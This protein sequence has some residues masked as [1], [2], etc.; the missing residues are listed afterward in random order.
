M[1]GEA[2]GGSLTRSK[3][4]FVRFCERAYCKDYVQ[5]VKSKNIIEMLGNV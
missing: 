2:D 4:L 1:R 3:K 5:K